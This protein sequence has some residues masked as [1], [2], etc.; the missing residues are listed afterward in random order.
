MLAKVWAPL[1]IRTKICCIASVEEARMAIGAGAWAVGLVSAMPSGQ[2]PISDDLIASIARQVGNEVETFLLTCR[3]DA[4]SIIEQHRHCQTSTLQLVDA[5]PA[6]EL[7]VLRSSLPRVRIVQVIH[8]HG[9]AAIGEALEIA[10]LVDM[11]LLDSGNPYLEVK[12]LGGTGR[13]HDWNHSAEI[14]RRSNV[15]VFLAGGLDAE[16]VNAA[17][18]RVRPFG[19][20]LCSGVRTARALDPLKLERF[21]AALAATNAPPG[22]GRLQG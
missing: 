22:T 17:V 4:A 16:N 3:Q 10:P 11:L 7:K 5:V 15:P 21:V 18:K 12:E 13:T 14:V 6:S 9:E 19:V 2:G 20:D 1:N 8:V